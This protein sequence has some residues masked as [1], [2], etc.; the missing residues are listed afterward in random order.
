MGTR[1][2]TGSLSPI[3]GAAFPAATP[4]TRRCAVGRVALDFH[5]EGMAEV[6]EALPRVRDVADIK[7]DPEFN[8]DLV[9]AVLAVV[10]VDVPGRAVR[11]NIIDR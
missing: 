8:E 5:I 1:A 2:T 3:S 4:S 9:D 10:D 6:G 7:A 11:V